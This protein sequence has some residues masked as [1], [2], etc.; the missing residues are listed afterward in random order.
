[1]IWN[2]V[3]F[4]KNMMILRFVGIQFYSIAKRDF[5]VRNLLLLAL[6]QHSSISL[7]KYGS[8]ALPKRRKNRSPFATKSSPNS[9]NCPS[10][11]TILTQN[12]LIDYVTIIH[13]VVFRYARYMYN[14]L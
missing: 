2:K 1:M 12:L 4:C 9:I 5:K 14:I 7:N 6:T 10:P 3:G 13:W 8:F 11:S